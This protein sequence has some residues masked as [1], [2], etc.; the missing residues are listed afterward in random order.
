MM[1]SRQTGS[2]LAEVI[3][4]CHTLATLEGPLRRP[5]KV[6]VERKHDLANIMG[7]LDRHCCD[8]M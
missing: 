1:I 8:R 7:E 4:S 3:E 5:L 6:R 2:S